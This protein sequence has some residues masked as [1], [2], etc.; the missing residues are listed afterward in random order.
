MPPQLY[1]GGLWILLI[2]MGGI[3]KRRLAMVVSPL[4]EAIAKAFGP[5]AATRTLAT[6]YGESARN[7]C[8]SPLPASAPNRMAG[9]SASCAPMSG[10]LPV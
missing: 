5:D 9:V 1:Q 2:M 8:Y 10:P 4:K 7:Q 6:S 3:V